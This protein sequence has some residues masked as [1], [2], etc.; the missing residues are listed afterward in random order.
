MKEIKHNHNL[1]EG[2]YTIMKSS[3]DNE[4]TGEKEVFYTYGQLVFFKG[5]IRIVPNKFLENPLSDVYIVGE[6]QAFINNCEGY[7]KDGNGERIYLMSS[8]GMH[9]F[10]QM[11]MDGQVA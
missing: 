11:F 2:F 10:H 5:S 9:K 8:K 6:H 1:M 4:E 7:I 3:F